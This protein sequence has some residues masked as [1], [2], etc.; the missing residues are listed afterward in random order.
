ML[1]D[2]FR[3]SSSPQNYVTCFDARTLRTC[4]LSICG[5]A[6]FGAVPDAGSQSS[7]VAMRL[8]LSSSTQVCET[9]HAC[10]TSCA[11]VRALGG[12]AW[13]TFPSMVT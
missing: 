6:R 5:S 10:P 2:P 9:L 12:D 4:Q 1:D 3:F 8:R 13:S 7:W 11:S